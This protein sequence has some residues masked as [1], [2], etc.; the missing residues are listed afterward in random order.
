M[1]LGKTHIGSM[2]IAMEQE[3]KMRCVHGALLSEHCQIC[4]DD[5]ER[6]KG[7]KLNM[8]KISRE[9]ELAAALLWLRNHYDVDAHIVFE[10]QENIKSAVLK[11]I[12][13]VLAD[14]PELS[15]EHQVAFR[16]KYPK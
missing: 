15:I 16:A 9:H 14:G 10:P 5:S 1:M 7:K 2:F 6:A 11:R 3:T 4:D 13:K 8:T 12:D